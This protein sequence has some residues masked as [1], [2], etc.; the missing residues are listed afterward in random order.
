MKVRKLAAGLAL[1]LA[2]L[3]GASG[4]ESGAEKIVRLCTI[5]SDRPATGALGLKIERA[6]KLFLEG[7]AA[8]ADFV[9]AADAVIAATDL[10]ETLACVPRLAEWGYKFEVSLRDPE[11]LVSNTTGALDF[12][13]LETDQTLRLVLSTDIGFPHTLS[14]YVHELTHICQRFGPRWQSWLSLSEAARATPTMLAA[15]QRLSYVDEIDANLAE[16]DFYN[17]VL[18]ASPIMCDLGNADRQLYLK[19]AEDEAWLASGHF[20]NAYVWLYASLDGWREKIADNPLPIFDVA[21]E[22][23]YV[24]VNKTVGFERNYPL[25]NLLRQDLA[26][27]GISSGLDLREYAPFHFRDSPSLTLQRLLKQA[28]CYGGRTDGLWGKQSV[29]AMR[30]LAAVAGLELSSPEPTLDN[31][32][33]LT[34][35]MA[36][37]D[38]AC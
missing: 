11:Q 1:Y 16:L 2:M 24:F 22:P 35:A 32:Y 29:A 34:R 27:I 5:E 26:E 36:E 4:A 19:R 20:G 23:I 8:Q 31:Y 37:R 7:S 13:T 10:A 28:E 30:R 25:S 9:A 17:A 21:A 38:I 14:V 33:D 18:P 6:Q 3:P 15:R 12:S